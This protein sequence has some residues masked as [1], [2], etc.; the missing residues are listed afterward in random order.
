MIYQV[1]IYKGYKFT[2]DNYVIPDAQL[3]RHSIEEAREEAQQAAH[4]NRQA[5]IYFVADGHVIAELYESHRFLEAFAF[6]SDEAF[7]K[8]REAAELETEGV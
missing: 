3:V 2:G 8:S 5:V 7:N 6:D 1:A 4:V